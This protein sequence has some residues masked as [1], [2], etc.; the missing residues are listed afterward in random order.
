MP[1]TLELAKAHGAAE[2][3]RD[4]AATVATFT[5]DCLYTIEAFGVSLQGREQAAEHYAGAFAAWPDFYNKEVIW[6][7]A[8]NDV[9][10]KAYVE[11]TH[12]SEWNGIAAT[13]K[14]IGFW[15][16][17]HFPRARDGLLLG[18]HVYMNGNEL[19]HKLG[20]LPSANAFELAA[21]IRTQEERIKKLEQALARK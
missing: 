11:L 12:N 7:D 2:D 13:G 8:G 14:K 17:A 18:E 19:L 3:R 10:A 1:T 5:Q 6:Y 21:H 4:V 16:A 20:A 9:W 15:S